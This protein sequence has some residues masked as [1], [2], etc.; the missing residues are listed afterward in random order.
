[1]TI[2]GELESDLMNYHGRLYQNLGN[3]EK[4]K[5]F[6][7]SLKIRKNLLGE[8]HSS[9]AF[10]L[11]N[12]G[13]LFKNFGNLENDEELYLKSLKIYQNL[14]GENHFDVA[15]SLNNLGMLYKNLGNLEKAEEFLLKSLK[16]YQNLF[17]EES[18]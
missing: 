16:I 13:I 18:C 11:W 9:V 8:N 2:K 4:A 7:K 14:F 15:T 17:S 10:S 1:M 5:E 3:L 12:L 6:I